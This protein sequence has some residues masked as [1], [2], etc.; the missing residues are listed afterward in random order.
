MAQPKPSDD[1]ILLAAEIGR[2]EA[3][4]AGLERLQKTF[5]AL[6]TVGFA[7]VAGLLLYGSS[8]PD[9][10]SGAAGWR[11]DPL[12]RRE[13]DGLREQLQHALAVIE[14]IRKNTEEIRIRSAAASLEPEAI[15][16]ATADP[17][18][19]TAAEA[20]A[21]RAGVNAGTDKQTQPA[22]GMADGDRTPVFSAGGDRLGEVLWQTGDDVVIWA[23]VDGRWGVWSSPMT[24]FTPVSDRLI[25]SE[26]GER[27][28]RAFLASE[29]EGAASR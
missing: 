14:D 6:V 4:V 1:F 18:A 7:V 25:L 2:L 27:Q 23:Q 16:E 12:E 19:E 28:L 8:D 10:R 26:A 15:G 5:I 13:I 9:Q 29:T 22:A 20:A 11:A 21:G 17:A 24:A 3:A